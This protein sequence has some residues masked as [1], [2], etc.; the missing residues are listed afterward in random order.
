MTQPNLVVK[1]Y[2]RRAC[3]LTRQTDKQVGKGT[4]D[5]AVNIITIP[6]QERKV[7]RGWGV[8]HGTELNTNAEARSQDIIYLARP[9][10]ATRDSTTQHGTALRSLSPRIV[11]SRSQRSRA[12]V[13]QIHANGLIGSLCFPSLTSVVFVLQYL[14]PIVT[15][16]EEEEDFFLLAVQMTRFPQSNK[17]FF[18]TTMRGPFFFSFSPFSRFGYIIKWEPTLFVDDEEAKMKAKNQRDPSTCAYT[19]CRTL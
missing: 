17:R 5:A 18:Y 13:S 1:T 16:T 15:V 11:M 19:L 14:C 7:Y 4:H 10:F 9:A 6:K 12:F 2:A 8:A 3:L